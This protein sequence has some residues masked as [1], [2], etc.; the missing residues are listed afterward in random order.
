MTAISRQL[1]FVCQKASLVSLFSVRG[2]ANIQ[3]VREVEKYF[4]VTFSI[5][6]FLICQLFIVRK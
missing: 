5:L 4:S 1:Q 3:D 6:V 2:K